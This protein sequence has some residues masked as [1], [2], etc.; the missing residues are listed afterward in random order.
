VSVIS[1]ENSD[2]LFSSTMSLGD[3]LEELRRRVIYALAGLAVG[4]GVC[5]AFGRWILQFLLM[6]YNR[7]VPDRPLS[8][9]GI[10]DAFVIYMKV[11]LVAGLIVASPW[12]FYHLWMFVSAG[13]YRHERRYVK[14]AVPFSASLFVAGALF[15]FFI[16]APVT[17]RYLLK[18]SQF[19]G[20][21]QA[22]TFDRY[23]SFMTLLMLVFGLAF[24]TPLAIFIVQRVGLVSIAALGRARKYVLLLM[25]IIAAFATPPD[26]FSQ[27][28][29]ALP[30][31]LLYELGILLCRVVPGR[32]QSE[33]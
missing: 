28:V 32:G 24:Q 2:E 33:K 3:H 10:P 20:G 21:Q 16:V 7:L 17:L 1:M 22:W 29:L 9:L 12:V 27:V 6:P 26:V 8:F 19:V 30:L 5:L 14:I 25:F 4:T 18:F 23:V 13:L 31:Y 15:F 11:S